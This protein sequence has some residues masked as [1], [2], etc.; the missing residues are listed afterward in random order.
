[1]SF[2]FLEISAGVRAFA[3]RRSQISSFFSYNKILTNYPNTIV[4]SAWRICFLTSK[5][6]VLI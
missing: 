1:M 4:M 3:I 2:C 6:L 5:L